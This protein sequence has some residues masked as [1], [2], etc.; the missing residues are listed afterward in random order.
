MNTG[1]EKE[2]KSGQDHRVEMISRGS[3]ELTGIEDVDSF[4]E[5][6]GVAETVMG[7]LSI[8]GEELRIESFSS[9]TGRLS[10]KGKIDGL[11]YFGDRGAKKKRAGSPK[12]R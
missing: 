12:S 9:G 8:E 6:S 5:S 11:F 2:Q 3:V 10:V 1:S 7:A 4:S